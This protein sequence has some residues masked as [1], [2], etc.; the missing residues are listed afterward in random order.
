M[1]EPRSKAGTFWSNKRIERKYTSKQLA[2]ILGCSDS[3][4]FN[5]LTG[6]S[7]PDL[8]MMKKIC[9]LFE[10]G[11]TEGAE[12]F[13]KAFEAWGE[14]HPNYKRTGNTY[15]IINRCQSKKRKPKAGKTITPTP[16]PTLCVGRAG[17]ADNFWRKLRVDADVSFIDLGKLLGCSPQQVRY[18]FSGKAHIKD[19][20]VHTLCEYF[21][22]D[23]D[24]GRKAFDDI[25]HIWELNHLAVEPISEPVV[26]D[27]TPDLP[28]YPMPEIKAPKKAKAE[29]PATDLNS[30]A[31]YLE[32][33]YAKIPY[34]EF[35][36][37]MTSPTVEALLANL[38][39]KVDFATYKALM[40]MT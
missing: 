26:D 38:Y 17:H 14:A 18:F 8:V 3:C 15:N 7:L 25:Q 11:Y 33:L 1:I 40:D 20:H 28:E 24:E 31:K 39:G 5:Y 37:L 23:F 4:V 10:V 29:K 34:D 36:K 2:D 13:N 6:K 16:T 35:N 30:I 27:I 21:D 32:V 9:D 22:V 19:A 12:E